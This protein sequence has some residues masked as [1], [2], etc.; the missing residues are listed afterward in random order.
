MPPLHHMSVAQRERYLLTLL[1]KQSAYTVRRSSACSDM[2]FR[3]NPDIDRN[4]GSL[5]QLVVM[6]KRLL[7]LVNVFCK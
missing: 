6:S 7:L 3:M 5:D 4:D 1:W 2:V